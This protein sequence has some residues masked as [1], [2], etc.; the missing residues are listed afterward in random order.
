VAAEAHQT[1]QLLHGHLAAI[2]ASVRCFLLRGPGRAA[3]RT[4]DAAAALTALGCDWTIFEHVHPVVVV[5]RF[6]RL[7]VDL[8][9]LRGIDPDMIRW[10]SEPWDRARKA[11]GF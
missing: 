10:D 4:D 6:Q 5:V 9:E 8:A 1:E 3:G 2:D 7:A 11:H